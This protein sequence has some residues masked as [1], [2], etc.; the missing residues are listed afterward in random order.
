[1]TWVFP[2]IRVPQNGWFIMEN[3]IKMDD[4]G[5]KPIILGNIH[6][7]HPFS[8]LDPSSRNFSSRSG[9]VRAR[10]C[11]ALDSKK[12]SWPDPKVGSWQDEPN[13]WGNGMY[14]PGSLTVRPWKYTIL[15]GKDRLPTIIFQ[16]RAVKLREGTID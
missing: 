9:M 3:L 12:S 15:K 1:M 10:R 11:V 16:G 2:K 5:G 7:F 6:I 4:L 13:V 8:N 14:P